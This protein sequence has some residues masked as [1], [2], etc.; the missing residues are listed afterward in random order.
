[1]KLLYRGGWIA[2]LVIS[3]LSL[4]LIYILFRIV[5]QVVLPEGIVPEGQWIS[6]IRDML[7][8]GDT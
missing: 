8:G 5:F 4:A 7:N 2:A 3:T 6:A 1:M